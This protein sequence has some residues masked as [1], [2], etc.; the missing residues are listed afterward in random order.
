MLLALSLSM[1]S[2]SSSRASDEPSDLDES[3]TKHAYRDELG[4]QDGTH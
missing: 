1:T 3:K 2:V 4:S